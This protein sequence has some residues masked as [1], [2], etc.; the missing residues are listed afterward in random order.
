LYPSADA[1][2]IDAD[3]EATDA[4][5][6]ATAA[7][8]T[9][10]PAAAATA[11]AAATAS[12][13]ASAPGES[14]A[15]GGS[16]RLQEDHG[17]SCRAPIVQLE[18]QAADRAIDWPRVTRLVLLEATWQKAPGMILHPHLQH[19]P[20]VKL[21]PRVSTFWR[22]Q[23]L[24]AAYLSTCEAAYYA[25]VELRERA[26]RH[27][28]AA[29]DSTADAA[30]QQ[31]QQAPH[32]AARAGSPRHAQYSGEFDDLLLLY[33]SRHAR[34]VNEYKGASGKKVLTVWRASVDEKLKIQ[35]QEAEKAE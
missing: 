4:A 16:A 25:C 27:S 23:E 21:R 14:A 19:L 11:T 12:A 1:V 2:A 18:Q 24:G 13:P 6:A 28:A 29:A 3:V 31:Q 22:H 26:L 17:Y 34:V 8:A 35:Q 9:A 5:T 7:T 20:R 33:A 32:P 30:E 10:P 15:A